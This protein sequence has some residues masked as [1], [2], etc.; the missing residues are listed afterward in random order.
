MQ[1]C[2]NTGRSCR[3]SSARAQRNSTPMQS[4]SWFESLDVQTVLGSGPYWIIWEAETLRAVQAGPADG[5][6]HVLQDVSCVGH[7][8]APGFPNVSSSSAFLICSVGM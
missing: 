2:S 5:H 3:I 6:I 7:V 8:S 1:Q 4:Q